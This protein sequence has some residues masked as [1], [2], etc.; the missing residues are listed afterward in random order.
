MCVCV[1][2]IK[3]G[4]DPRAQALT[5]EGWWDDAREQAARASAR[6]DVVAAL[7]AAEAAPKPPLAEMF[8]DVYAEQ[9]PHLAEQEDE[10]REFVRRFPSH[11]AQGGR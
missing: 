8:R 7:D 9:P 2:V 6:R 3:R 10:V 11:Y 4:P 1:R 5:A